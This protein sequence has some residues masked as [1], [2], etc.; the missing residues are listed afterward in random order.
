MKIRN[1]SDLKHAVEQAGTASHF[2]TRDTM[3]HWG[4]RMSNY[5]LRQPRPVTLHDGRTVN[6]YELT[7]KRPVKGG[8]RSSAWFDAETFKRVF[9]AEAPN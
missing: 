9:P 3:R 1:A 4:D 5:G 6:A 2:F 8:L 7:R